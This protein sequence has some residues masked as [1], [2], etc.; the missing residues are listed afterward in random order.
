MAVIT[1][2]SNS[3]T[4]HWGVMHLRPS[5]NQDLSRGK[6]LRLDMPT[7]GPGNFQPNGQVPKYTLFIP[8]LIRYVISMNQ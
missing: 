7:V 8:F 5:S 4:I 1:V 6:G 3:R 2:A